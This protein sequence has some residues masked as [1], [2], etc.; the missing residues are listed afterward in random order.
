MG[1]ASAMAWIM[2]IIVGILTI[3]IFTTS[4]YWVHYESE[5]GK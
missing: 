1:Y 2:L 3:I 5:G 4:K